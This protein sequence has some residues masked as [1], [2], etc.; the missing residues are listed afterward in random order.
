MKYLA[1]LNH[2]PSVRLYDKAGKYSYSDSVKL[3]ESLSKWLI[4]PFSASTCHNG[5]PAGTTNKNF[6]PRTKC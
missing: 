5:K 6:A 4:Q 1:A 2:Q 3:S